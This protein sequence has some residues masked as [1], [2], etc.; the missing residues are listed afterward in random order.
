MNVDR[1]V[2][3]KNASKVDQNV[4]FL[5]CGSPL[6]QTVYLLLLLFN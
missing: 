1:L 3:G 5:M 4:K 6:K 2:A